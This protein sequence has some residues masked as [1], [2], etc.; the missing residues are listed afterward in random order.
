MNIHVKTYLRIWFD[1]HTSPLTV[2]RIPREWICRILSEWRLKYTPKCEVLSVCFVMAKQFNLLASLRQARIINNRQGELW[3]LFFEV[4]VLALKNEGCIVPDGGINIP[5]ACTRCTARPSKLAVKPSS[6]LGAKL[7]GAQQV[8]SQEFLI[9]FWQN[10]LL[11]FMAFHFCV[12][13]RL[14]L[15]F[16]AQD[17]LPS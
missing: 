7:H 12:V 8:D 14:Q 1:I 4:V 13:W 2:T 5:A 3:W 6:T 11:G 10:V 17:W 16:G 15:R 9:F